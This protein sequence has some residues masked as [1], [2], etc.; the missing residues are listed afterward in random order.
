MNQY[1]SNIQNVY[2][3]NEED[4]YVAANSLPSY[5][6]E[7]IDLKTTDIVFSGIFGGETLD[8]S[9]GNPNSYHGLY[10]GDSITYIDPF[11]SSNSL[12]IFSKK[13]N[14]NF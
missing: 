4:I 12:G 7:S 2:L 6:D 13:Q 9:S 8:L 5:L 14:F 1:S 3:K 10:T 11:D